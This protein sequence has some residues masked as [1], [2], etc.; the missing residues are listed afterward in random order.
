MS[1]KIE[2]ILDGLNCAHCAQKIEDKISNLSY[3]ENA[4][5][6]FVAKKLSVYMKDSDINDKNVHEIA[7]II[8]DTEDGLSI[9]LASN[10]FV[11]AID[12][13][14]KGGGG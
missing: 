8:D 1:A 6:N 3:V 12:F 2:F 7:D 10:K 5:M 11:G 9:S 13:S 14:G 4:N